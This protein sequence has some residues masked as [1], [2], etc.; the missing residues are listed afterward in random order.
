MKKINTWFKCEYPDCPNE[1]DTGYEIK[2]KGKKIK[3]CLDCYK[4]CGGRSE[5]TLETGEDCESLFSC[6]HSERPGRPPSNKNKNAPRDGKSL[7]GK[8]RVPAHPTL[9]KPIA[10]IGFAGFCRGASNKGAS[11]CQLLLI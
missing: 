10:E 2:Y 3:V 1:R 9:N 4:K 8:T 7:A 5:G 11:S 6:N